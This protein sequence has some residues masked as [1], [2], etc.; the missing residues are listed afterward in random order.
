M[1]MHTNGHAHL[2]LLRAARKLVDSQNTDP[3]LPDRLT[4]AQKILQSELPEMMK[5]VNAHL[6]DPADPHR[7]QQK[8][9]SARQVSYV[10]EEI[11][12]IIRTV[13]VSYASEFR[14]NKVPIVRQ[15][16]LSRLENA[17]KRINDMLVKLHTATS[18]AELA[19]ARQEL[20]DNTRG[21]VDSVRE[22]PHTSANDA[23]E[24]VRAVKEG[25]QPEHNK[26]F[27]SQK[28]LH[29]LLDNMQ[30]HVAKL[31]PSSAESNAARDMRED[32]LEAAKNMLASLKGIESTLKSAVDTNK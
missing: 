11:A 2:T 21:L 5:R 19:T 12:N 25:M 13:E 30:E 23:A 6:E 4:A 18:D 28:R 20:L 31:Q 16:A 32:L 3:R 24:F 10:I 8:A 7:L 1:Y 17:V 22:V 26:L 29:D 15:A 14:T 9:E 27:A